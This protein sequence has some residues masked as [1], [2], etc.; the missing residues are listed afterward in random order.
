MSFFEF[1]HTRTYDSDLGWLIKKMEE[2]ATAY[3]SLIDWKNQHTQDY[4][5]LISR[6]SALEDIIN[7]FEDE[8]E[9]RFNTLEIELNNEISRQIR[10][11][12]ESITLDL[13]SILAQLSALQAG[14]I[15]E[16]IDREA[17]IKAHS[18]YLELWVEAK[19]QALINSIPDLTTVNVFNPVRGEVTSIQVAINDLYDLGRAEA[20]T[21]L[22]YDT[23]SLTAQDYDDLELTAYQYDNYGKVLMSRYYKN[24]EHYMTSPF[25][26][27]YVLISV[28]VNELAN[29]HKGDALTAQEYDLKDLTA[30]D[31]DTLDLT[32]Y[33]YD[34]YGKT[35][36]S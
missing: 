12:I 10:E 14:L 18:D 4:N 23:M 11:A 16:R 6:V 26:G 8:I 17:S 21:A 34:W 3:D 28:V 2:I 19:I 32:A 30:N 1:P 7:S 9:E 33:Q 29:L 24:P 13:D 36:I 20:L 31:Y 35:L 5:S 15:R 25:T 27:D 22:E